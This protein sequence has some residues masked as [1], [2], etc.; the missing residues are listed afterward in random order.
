M[1]L[2]ELPG[3]TQPELEPS[4]GAPSPR[5]DYDES[6]A[7]DGAPVVGSATSTRFHE[8]V[9]LVTGCRALG[10]PDITPAILDVLTGK[11]TEQLCELALT[12][13]SIAGWFADAIDQVAD[14]TGTRQLQA[15]AVWAAVN[16]P[17]GET[18]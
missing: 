9:S 13:A 1:H 8:A 12:C 5:V 16:L 18:P 4:G 6:A 3:W 11:S 10:E 7:A 14:G 2:F 15:W 17:P